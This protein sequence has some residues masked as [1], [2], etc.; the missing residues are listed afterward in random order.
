[1]VVW[2]FAGLVNVVLVCME[3]AL[4]VAAAARQTIA[5]RIRMRFFSAS[6]K[7]HRSITRPR[8]LTAIRAPVIFFFLVKST[9]KEATALNFCHF[10]RTDIHIHRSYIY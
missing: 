3:M 1:M 7:I 4:V 10:R 8:R 2:G 9:K 6:T 5:A